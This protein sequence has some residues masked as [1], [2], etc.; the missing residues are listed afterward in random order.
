MRVLSF[1]GALGA[2]ILGIGIV[3]AQAMPAALDRAPLP[4]PGPIVAVQLHCDH[5]RCIDLHTGAYTHSGCNRG[6]CY[7]TGGIVGYADPRSL[8]LGYGS[9]FPPG[10]HRG[11]HHRRWDHR[12][13]GD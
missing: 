11:H 2:A 10:D 1:V 8:G 12:Y 4:A 13:Y 5:L 7:P 9:S 6:G 3:Q